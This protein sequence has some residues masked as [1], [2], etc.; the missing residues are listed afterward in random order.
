LTV[1]QD[2]SDSAGL[3][4]DEGPMP[5]TDLERDHLGKRLREERERVLHAL[6]TYDEE[7]GTTEQDATGDLSKYP[8]HPA[9]EATEMFDRE[10]DAQEA[11]RLSGELE[12]IDAA[13]ERLYHTPDRFGRDERT[14]EEI[15]F[16]RLVIIPWARERV[17]DP[18]AEAAHLRAVDTE[19]RSAEHNDRYAG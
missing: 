1:R 17:D 11:S 8:F 14:G 10:L 7:L 19:V 18:P 2:F 6:G 3:I 4:K 16:E 12:E 13:L 15:P 5:L 9:D